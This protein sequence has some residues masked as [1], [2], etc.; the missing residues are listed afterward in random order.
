MNTQKKPRLVL[1]G[2]GTGLAGLRSLLKAR[3]AAGHHR[4]WLLFGERSRAHDF[5]YR[6]ELETWQAQG[7][8]AH[9]DLAFSRD[10]AARVYVQDLLRANLPRLREWMAEGASIHVCGAL[11]GMAPGV[12]AVLQEAFGAERVEQWAAEGRYRRDVY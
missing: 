3:I 7:A 12:D 10:Q 6:E 2:N 5:H 11:H 9:T 4:N 1:V 8:L